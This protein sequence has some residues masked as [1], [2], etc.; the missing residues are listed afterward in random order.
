MI[1]NRG[2]AMYIREWAREEQRAK[3]LGSYALP[4][5]APAGWKYIGQGCYRAAYLS[6]DRVIYKIQITPGRWCGQSNAE[7]YKRW[8][9]LRLRYREL[10]GMRWPL[11]N[12]FEFGENDDVNAMDYVGKTLSAYDGPDRQDYVTTAQRCAWHLSLSDMH[13]GNLA[14]DEQRKLLVPIDLGM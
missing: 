8:W 7:E 4:R 14:V 2:Y 12:L 5:E 10:D 3:N 13:H 9:E 6:P 11:V 1:G